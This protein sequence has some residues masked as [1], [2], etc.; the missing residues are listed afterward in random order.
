MRRAGWR[1]TWLLAGV[2]FNLASPAV[3]APFYTGGDISLSPFLEGRGA[4]YRDGG[5][6]RPIENILVD[7]GANLFR[8]RLFVNPSLNYD[9]PSNRGAIQNLQY[10]I[11]QAQR[12]KASGAKFMLALHLSDTWADPGAQQTP[13]AWSGQSLSQL[14][15]TVRTYT[16]DTLNAF[17][18][19][20]VMPDMVQI[21]NETTSGM[22]WPRGQLNFNGTTAQLNASWANFGQLM[23]AAIAG[24]RQVQS[25][26]AKIDVAVT[27]APGDE[28]YNSSVGG[29]PRWFV[30]NFQTYGGVTDYDILGIDSYPTTRSELNGLISNLNDLANRYDR[31]VMVM[32]TSYPWNN[33]LDGTAADQY[34]ASTEPHP[35]S[36]EGQKSYL[37]E[38]RDA[39]RALPHQRGAGVLWWYP[40][41]V[42]TPGTY[43]WKNGAL[44][45]FDSQGN[46]L[47]VLNTLDL[48]DLD[49]DGDLDAADLN[50]L[51]ASPGYT[52]RNDVNHDGKVITSV[53][54]IDSDVDAWVR[55]FKHTEY[56][57]VN[58]NGNVDFDDLLALAQ[59]YNAPGDWSSGDLNGT[60]FVDFADLLLLAQNYGFGAQSA[61]DFPQAFAAAFS[62][63]PTSASVLMLLPIVSRKRSAAVFPGRATRI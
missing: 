41:A 33:T 42:P 63:E 61:M 62:P 30:D 24:V 39:I 17:K 48:A 40:E 26:G 19:A 1:L 52:V 16:V 5:T 49:V 37:L 18:S 47:P 44:G 34:N 53:N 6:V 36:V 38:L 46:A 4:V 21:G 32:E 55:V 2:T 3:A 60:H 58:L 23:N 45:T 59:H 50:A 22:L 15:Q 11:A 13:A 43:V 57:D 7:R 12:V 8:L 10:T 14:T 28:W 31:K 51:F 20:G 9:A 25:A 54:T 29:L 35:T 56:G 27:I